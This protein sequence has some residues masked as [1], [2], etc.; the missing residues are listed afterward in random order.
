MY[1]IRIESA[2][3]K[4]WNEVHSTIKEAKAAVKELFSTMS[5][6]EIITLI[7]PNGTV[8]KCRTR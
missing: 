1:T 2:Y 3:T 5:Y 8:L 7:A 4:A 6:G